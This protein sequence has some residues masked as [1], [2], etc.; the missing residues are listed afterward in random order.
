M[1]DRCGTTWIA[2]EGENAKK[3]YDI[4][5]NSHTYKEHPD[6][7]NLILKY[8]EGLLI[9]MENWWS[10]STFADIIPLLLGD[11][12]YYMQHD[13]LDEEW[14]TNDKE[15]KYFTIPEILADI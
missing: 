6:S 13:D 5:V 12:Y 14:E 8:K 11:D 9:I 4:I 7:H 2:I 1:S 15:G 3:I 10:G